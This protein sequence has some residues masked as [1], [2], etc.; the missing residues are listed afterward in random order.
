MNFRG[1]DGGGNPKS[2]IVHDSGLE[3]TEN[4]FDRTVL[5]VLGVPN[6]KIMVREPS[7]GAKTK[8]LP[9]IRIDLG[10]STFRN[11]AVLA[12]TVTCRDLSESTGTGSVVSGSEPQSAKTDLG[13]AGAIRQSSSDPRR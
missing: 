11:I 3:S 6:S 10:H 4:R 13:V 7:A 5:Y 1:P 12:D 2:E 9:K 8:I